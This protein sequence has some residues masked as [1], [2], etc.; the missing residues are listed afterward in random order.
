MDEDRLQQIETRAIC[1]ARG[2]LQEDTL[3]L[4][5]EVRRL[6]QLTQ[7]LADRVAAREHLRAPACESQARTAEDLQHITSYHVSYDGNP[8]SEVLKQYGSS[9][10]LCRFRKGELVG[11]DERFCP[12]CDAD[13][14]HLCRYT[15]HER[16][17]SGNYRQCTVCGK[18][19]FG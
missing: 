1:A 9:K 11:Q 17:S 2:I 16:D 6:R 12:A 7:G 18:E 3:A 19:T 13:T 14:L 10:P 15:E 4:A 5:A 8:S